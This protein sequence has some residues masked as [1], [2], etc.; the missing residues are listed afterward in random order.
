VLERT[1]SEP[2]AIDRWDSLEQPAPRE[3]RAPRARRWARRHWLFL[4]LLLAGIVL[5]TLAMVAYVPSLPLRSGDAYQYLVRAVSMSVEQSYHPFL[6]SVLLK[7]FTLGSLAWLTAVQHLAGIATAVLI[8]LALTRFGLSH[9]LAALGAA[10]VLLDGYQIALEHQPLTETFFELFGVGGLVLAAWST[11]PGLGTAS[12]AGF[13]LGL[14]VLIR[15]AGFALLP[16]VVVFLLTRRVQW[17]RLAALVA[18]FLIPLLGY[19]VWF[20]TQTG[21]FGLTNRNGFYLYGR[22]ADFANCRDVDVPSRERVLC[23]E[24]LKHEPGRGLFNAGLPGSIRQDPNYNDLA[25]SFARR[26]IV[27]KPGSFALAVA[28]DLGKFFAPE[29]SAE[30]DRW[31]VARELSAR[32]QRHVP[33]GI[34]AQFRMR[35]GP[36]V[37]LRTW[38][39]AVWLRGPL[40][41]LMLLLGLTGAIVGWSRTSR[42]PFGPESLLFTAASFGLLLF[43]T[44]FAV[45]HFRYY[46]PAIP[47]AG[48]AGA[49]GLATLSAWLRRKRAGRQAGWLAFPG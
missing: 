2:Q 21:T 47:F 38:Q 35:P 48:A 11:R 45:Y 22:V 4:V 31:L 17:T 26:M 44:I 46:V 49:I 25:E 6:Y 15:F 42:P 7:P 10:P 43:P 1:E 18:S 12:A 33:A 36:A 37:V 13:L 19:A 3:R 20:Q 14:S 39:K 9:W 30:S 27:A 28:S 34:D 5:R 24:K 16:A 29:P 32:D 8:Y 23:P 40:L 41:A